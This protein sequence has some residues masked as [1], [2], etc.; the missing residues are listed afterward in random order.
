MRMIA[1]LP[2][3]RPDLFNNRGRIDS[4]NVTY[5]EGLLH[6]ALDGIVPRDEL[7]RMQASVDLLQQYLSKSL[8]EPLV[9]EVEA[10]PL[11]SFHFRSSPPE[12]R[13]DNGSAP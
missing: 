5:R 9:V 11:D 12:G 13:A 3:V 6:V 8:G 2:A 10:I 7:P 1:T 4:L